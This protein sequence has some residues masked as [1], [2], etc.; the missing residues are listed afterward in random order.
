VHLSLC[1]V[2]RTI[3]VPFDQRDEAN[4]DDNFQHIVTVDAKWHALEDHF[5]QKRERHPVLNVG[6]P[7][8]RMRAVNLD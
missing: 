6:D 3:V 2:H 8:N 1:S 7:R 4:K 5:G